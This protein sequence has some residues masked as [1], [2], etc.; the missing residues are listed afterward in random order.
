MSCDACMNPPK[1]GEGLAFILF[2]INCFFPGE[3]VCKAAYVS[4]AYQVCCTSHGSHVW[5]SCAH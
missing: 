2:I 4:R 3:A 5:A 1:T